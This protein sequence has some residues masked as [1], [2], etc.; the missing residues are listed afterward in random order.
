[1]SMRIVPASSDAQS[2]SHVAHTSSAPSAP[3]VHDTLRH[4]VG[5]SPYEA[6]ATT[7]T[8][9]QP[10][11]P[12]S[13]HPLE[14]RLKNWEATQESLRMESLRR[15]FGMAEPIRRGMELNIVRR[16]EWRPLAL[17]PGLP[18]VHEEI[19]RGREATITWEDVYTGEE[20]RGVPAFHDEM[21]R[22]VKMQ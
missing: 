9:S 18:S 19:L 8:A 15:T 22:K 5:V 1:M 13:S 14:A 2:F 17:G 6:A 7:I 20:S 10:A 3:G 21:E 4:G 12:V 11:A 16:G